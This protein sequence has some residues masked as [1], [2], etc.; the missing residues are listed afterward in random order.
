M[1]A[2]RAGG[3]WR[4]RRARRV[5]GMFWLMGVAMPLAIGGIFALIVWF[6]NLGGLGGIG[7]AFGFMM[8]AELTK[9]AEASASQ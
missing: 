9:I 3:V 7:A 2:L 4:A 1:G 5:L 8:T 6:P